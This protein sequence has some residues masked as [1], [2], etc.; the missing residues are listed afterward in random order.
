[1]TPQAID[2]IPHYPARVRHH[3]H[4]RQTRAAHKALIKLQEAEMDAVRKNAMEVPDA[5][6][7]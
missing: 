7:N 2:D 5:K 4:K 1:M 3:I 6:E